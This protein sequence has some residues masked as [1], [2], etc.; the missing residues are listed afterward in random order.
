MGVFLI[1]ESEAVGMPMFK[2]C[3]RC[4]KRIP[5]GSRCSCH[6]QRHKEYDRLSRD[7]RTKQFYDSKEWEHA[8]AAGLEADEGIDVY[9]YM[10]SGKIMAADTVHHI[11][12]LKDNW[13]KRN[14]VDNL[15]S[16][17]HD[18]HSMIEQM[19]KQDKHGMIRKLQEMV[20]RYREG[21]YESGG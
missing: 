18:T 17:H 4:G 2:R 20:Q 9:L 7:R 6:T 5:S 12:P 1:A 14:D 10:T 13:E 21:L 8:R 19:Y 11:I 16:L 3:S 15:M